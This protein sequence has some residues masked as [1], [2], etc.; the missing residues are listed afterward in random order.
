VVVDVLNSAL[1]ATENFGPEVQP[2]ARA[3]E[4][5]VN[6]LNQNP[7]LTNVFRLF[8]RPPRASTCDCE[9]PAEPALPQTLYLMTDPQIQTKITGGRLKN[10]LAGKKT[11]V[12]VI[13]ELFLAT[14]CRLPSDKE[15]T[16]MTA[17]VQ[18]KNNR[19]AG[20]VDVVWALINSREFILNH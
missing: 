20:L 13:E 4:V 12:E 5:A 16:R 19:Q 10:L 11:D 3:I 1:G 6:R 18:D 8:G 2:G 17:H 14:L 7:N 9:R 15:R